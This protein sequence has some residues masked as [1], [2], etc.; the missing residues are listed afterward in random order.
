MT[1]EKRLRVVQACLWGTFGWN[2]SM[3]AV[4]VIRLQYNLAG[5]QLA[6]CAG[7]VVISW[8]T[9]RV[10]AYAEALIEQT[11][12]QRDTAQ[13]IQRQTEVDLAFIQQQQRTWDRH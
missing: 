11:R 5:L 7:I 9:N 10:D 8:L 4:N 3:V 6:L 12:A 13:M 1:P 2:I